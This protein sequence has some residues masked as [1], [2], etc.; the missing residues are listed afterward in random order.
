MRKALLLSVLAACGAQQAGDTASP[1]GGNVSFGGAQDIGE[2]R[3]IL[4]KGGIPGPD[5][6]D[7]NGFF[8]EH[9][10]APPPADCGAQLCLTPG[11]SVGHDWLTGAKQATVQLSIT[12][13][14]DPS[15]YHRLPLNMVLVIDR[16]GSMLEDGRLDKVKA[17]IATLIDKLQDGDRLAIIDFD[18]RVTVDAP[19]SA[20]LDRTHLK[21]VVAALQP[22]G[23]TDIDAGL[24][25]GFAQLADAPGDHQ[26]RV[27]LLSDG[28]ATSGIT[29]DATIIADAD[30]AIERGIGLTT[31]GVGTDFDVALMRGL[32]EHGA[33]NF[34]FLEDGSAVDEVFGQELDYFVNPLAL[35]VKVTATA[36]SGFT[37][38][39]VIGTHLWSGDSMSIPAV[40]LSS[41][42]SQTGEPGRRGGGSMVFIHAIPLGHDGA[43]VGTFDLSYRL[44]NSAEVI[45]QHVSLDY[46]DDGSD[47]Y[48]SSPEMAERYA[49]YNTFLGFRFATQAYDPSC[50]AA[51]LRATKTAATL[52]NDEH[53]DPDIAADLALMDT[54][55]TNLGTY[56]DSAATLDTCAAD[57]PYG[58]G[59]NYYGGD[60]TYNGG[61]ACSAGGH[62]TGLL[63]VGLALLLVRRRR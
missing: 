50:A 35:D 23:G 4:T 1:G 12:T 31:I 18:D 15:T 16:S 26:N 5:T 17:G 53:A 54:Y 32:A 60:D 62:A 57:N 2:F 49:M 42:T 58:E 14:V 41:R 25:A 40:F 3:D 22:R 51:A 21:S 52:W 43:H 24:K 20:E 56:A 30:A 28:I 44:P 11:L 39:E 34:Y 36:G 48:L 27:I 55:L 10:N 13:P 59:G 37:F 61:Y 8:N 9:Y 47:L 46:T 29:I 19:L 63:P 6:L 33:G 38:D 7:A 45:T